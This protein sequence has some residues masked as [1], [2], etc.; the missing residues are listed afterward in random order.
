MCSGRRGCM[1][2]NLISFLFGSKLEYLESLIVEFDGVYYLPV[3]EGI[4]KIAEIF[5]ALSTWSLVYC[6][7]FFIGCAFLLYASIFFFEHIGRCRKKRIF[8]F[9]DPENK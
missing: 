5:G 3:E 2:Q 1:I 8:G 4:R 6:G 9:S 7:F